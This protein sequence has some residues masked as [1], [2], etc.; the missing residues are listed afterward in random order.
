MAVE[1]ED[2]AVGEQLILR[3]EIIYDRLGA[4]VDPTS[5]SDV[6]IT[7]S[8]GTVLQTIASASIVKDSTGKYH[9]TTTATWNTSAQR[10]KDNWTFVYSGVTY[11]KNLAT[12]IS[13]T[14]SPAVG[15]ASFVTLVKRKIQAPTIGLTLLADPGDY[16]AFVVEAAK[17][18]S[19][20]RPYQQTSKLTGDGTAIFTLPTD[21]DNEV[22]LITQI[23]YPLD[24]NPPAYIETSKYEVVQLDT[25]WVGRFIG[26]YYPGSSEYFYVRYTKYH[27]V[28]AS[29]TTIPDSHKEA[30]CNL[31]ASIGC[32]ALAQLYGHT[33]NSSVEAD[34]IN[35]REKGDM[36][37]TRSKELRKLYDGQVKEIFSGVIGEID[38]PS[39]WE[40]NK[41]MLNRNNRMI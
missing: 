10:V 6:T 35:Y 8:N 20:R 21:W 37:S 18:Y 38:M 4:F 15:L 24:S 11:K 29:A 2:A 1:R 12:V 26:E 39:Y 28:T 22:S 40:G 7:D 34:A 13:D 33:A 41:D 32:Q 23:E 16:N 9:I 25:G 5:F 3:I 14:S 17:E 30:V 36:F 31:A 19:K 27:T